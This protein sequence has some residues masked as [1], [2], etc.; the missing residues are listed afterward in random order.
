MASPLL[1]PAAGRLAI[2]GRRA[3][4][5]PMTRVSLS[6]L[7]L[8]GSLICVS[9]A[10]WSVRSEPP[11]QPYQQPARRRGFMSWFRGNQD[12]QTAPRGTAAA[13]GYGRAPTTRR[14]RECA[15]RRP[16]TR[17]KRFR[18]LAT[19]IRKRRLP[20]RRAPA[21]AARV[22]R[23]RVH[24]IASPAKTAPRRGCRLGR[25]SG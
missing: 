5:R 7:I 8:A 10:G 17:L 4:V 1:Q 19:A 9:A 15:P 20:T 16:R 2:E 6:R 23:R 11:Q 25:R 14:W 21:A 3:A 12:D 13:A 22:R 24:E 18:R